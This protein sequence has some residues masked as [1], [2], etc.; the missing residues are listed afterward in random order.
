M[1]EEAYNMGKVLS[2][3]VMAEWDNRT[4]V[5]TFDIDHQWP[6][7]GC[8]VDP[9]SYMMPLYSRAQMPK[10]YIEFDEA[11]MTMVV[12]FLEVSYHRVGSLR[13]SLVI[14]SSSPARTIRSCGVSRLK[15][16]RAL[17]ESQRSMCSRTQQATVLAPSPRK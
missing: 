10:R 12:S 5:D 4:Q 6:V 17:R 11:A 16:P 1:W 8:D 7:Y 13:Y 15:N 2:D 3:T 14:F 9:D